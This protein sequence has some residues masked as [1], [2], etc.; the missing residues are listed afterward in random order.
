MREPLCR[1][2]TVRYGPS[3]LLHISN[4]LTL[5]VL[6]EDQFSLFIVILVLASTAILSS[7]LYLHVQPVQ[8][9]RCTDYRMIHRIIGHPAI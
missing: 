9:V 6:L 4:G 5:P 1:C 7:L 2:K 8:P 3:K